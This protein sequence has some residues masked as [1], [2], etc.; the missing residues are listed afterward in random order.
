MSAALWT[1]SGACIGVF[2]KHTWNLDDCS[3]WADHLAQNMRPALRDA[4]ISAETSTEEPYVLPAGA[5]RARAMARSIMRR[6]STF[7][8][9]DG[10]NKATGHFPNAF[11]LSPRSASTIAHEAAA[12]SANEDGPATSARGVRALKQLPDIGLSMV[13]SENNGRS[14]ACLV[15]IGLHKQ[16]GTFAEE[17]N[18]RTLQHSQTGDTATC[19][20]M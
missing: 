3:T 8:E 20:W 19:V 14:I 4:D 13:I 17:A 16:V 5:K 9:P 15:S 2:G 12:A 11:L 6:A 18:G 7:V 10:A 1:M